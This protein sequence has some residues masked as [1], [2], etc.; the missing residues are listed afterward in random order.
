MAPKQGFWTFLKKIKLLVLSG[1]YIKW[2]SLC[3]LKFCKNCLF[4]NIPV[5]KFLSYSWPIR[6]EHSFILNISGMDCCCFCCTWIV[7]NEIN[8]YISLE[9]SC[10]WHAVFQ[11][12]LS[13]LWS[14]MSSKKI[15]MWLSFFLV[16][17]D[18]ATNKQ[19]IL[20]SNRLAPGMLTAK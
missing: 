11:R 19:S 2:K 12:D 6:F 5:L 17:T 8:K 15:R 20:V 13:I 16:Q 9:Q 14:A 10:P 3:F 4:R 18:S 1:N 7:I